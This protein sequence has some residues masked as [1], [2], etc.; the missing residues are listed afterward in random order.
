MELPRIGWLN[1]RPPFPSTNCYLSWEERKRGILGFPGL[2]IE[3]RFWSEAV[4][5]IFIEHAMVN[6]ASFG[7]LG[8]LC[9][10]T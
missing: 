7:Q 3:V 10:V 4:L 2:A 1:G 8:L 9:K 6:F 5:S